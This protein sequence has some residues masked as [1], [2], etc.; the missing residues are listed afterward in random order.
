MKTNLGTLDRILRISFA[1]VVA[2]LT[3]TG[4]ISG[5]LAITLLVVATILL[6]TAFVGFCPIYYALGIR[7]DKQRIKHV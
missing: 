4:I 2:L 3:F 5:V 7:S 1:V 6:V